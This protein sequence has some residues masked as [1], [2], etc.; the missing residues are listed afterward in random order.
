MPGS[1]RDWMTPL[2]PLFFGGV[3]GVD[4]K[5][6]EYF[7]PKSSSKVVLVTKVGNGKNG[8]SLPG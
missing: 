8:S 2:G 5:V 6:S 7:V 4:P 3:E 1:L